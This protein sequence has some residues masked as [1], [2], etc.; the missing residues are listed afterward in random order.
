MV[1]LGDYGAT[2]RLV[3]N[4]RVEID[5]LNHRP[6]FSLLLAVKGYSQFLPVK[7]KG[8]LLLKPDFR[9]PTS[10][11]TIEM[12]M[13]VP[14]SDSRWSILAELLLQQTKWSWIALTSYTSAAVKQK[15]STGTSPLQV[16]WQNPS[17]SRLLVSAMFNLPLLDT[18]QWLSRCKMKKSGLI[19]RYFRS[20][21]RQ[22]F[23]C[24]N[25][26]RITT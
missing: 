24:L 10:I 22:A 7:N 13:N 6:D 21:H 5:C 16:S 11:L 23:A 12:R 2:Q 15:G 14:Q 25:I 26:M 1:E 9:A 20:I 3:W 18:L 4:S 19:E 8:C 17:G